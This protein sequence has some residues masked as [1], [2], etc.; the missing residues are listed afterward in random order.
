LDLEA[1]SWS[2]PTVFGTLP[3][4]RAGHSA[5]LVGDTW[6]VLGGGNNVKGECWALVVDAWPAM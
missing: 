4:P 6:Y 1:R 3:S 2:R 5:A